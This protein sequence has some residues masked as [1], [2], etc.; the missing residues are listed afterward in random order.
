MKSRWE[1]G[2]MNTATRIRSTFY[3]AMSAFVSHATLVEGNLRD[4]G[5]TFRCLFVENENLMGYMVSR[6][7]RKPPVVLKKW[8]AWIPGLKKTV[9]SFS[10]SVDMAV[11]VLPRRYES[12]LEGIASFK[13]QAFVCSSIDTTGNWSDVKGR[14]QHNKR[15]FSN[16]MDRQATF[17]CRISKDL[18]DLD[19]FYNDMYVPHLRNKF[20]SL[21]YIDSYEEI[22][23]MFLQ[24]FLLLIEEGDQSVAGV[25]CDIRHNTLICRRTGILHGNETYIRKGA[26]SA[27]YYYSLRFALEQGLSTVDLLRS[28]PFLNDG[29]YNTKRRWGARISPDTRSDTWVF[30][31]I[32]WYSRKVVSFFESNPTISFIDNKMYGMVGWNRLNS[33]SARDHTKFINR[34]YAPGLDGLLLVRPDSEPLEISFF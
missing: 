13:S 32:P 22:K 28:R 33:P 34:Y 19:L 15:Q 18:K 27:Q 17:S 6:M 23:N 25:L 20:Q 2:T 9:D 7:Y 31:F 12:I 8:R 29:V 21:A 5:E 3:P 26:S 16:R 30:F 4:T 24:G 10:P 14:F 11:A 1:E